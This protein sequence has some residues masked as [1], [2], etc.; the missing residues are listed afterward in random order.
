MNLKIALNDFKNNKFVSL[1]TAIFITVGASLIS[2]VLILIVNLT[3]SIDNLMTKAKTPDFLQMHQ[4]DIDLERLESF[5]KGSD[6]VKEY[7]TLD[8]LNIDRDKIEINGISQKNSVND[9]GFSVQ[10]EK[11]DYLLDLNNELIEVNPGEIYLPIIYIKDNIAAVGDK[12]KV[13]GKEFEIKGFLRDSQMNSSMAGSKRFLIHKDDYQAIENE[14]KKEYLI[15]FILNDRDKM[16]DFEKAYHDN[17]SEKNGPAVTYGMFKMINAI[18]DGIFIAVLILASIL[19][20]AISF[21]CISFSLNAKIEDE[22]R[23][24]GVMKAIGIRDKDVKKLYLDQYLIVSLIAIIKAYVLSL[25]AQNYILKDIFLYMGIS[26]NSQMAPIVAMIGMV[27]LFLI[28]VLFIS[29]MLNRIKKVSTIQAIR[30]GGAEE[31][32]LSKKMSLEKNLFFGKDFFLGL[33]EVNAK[34]K[35]YLSIFW[36]ILLASLLLTIPQNLYS[37]LKDENFMT[38]L[39]IGKTDA[40]IDVAQVDNPEILAPK[41]L[42]KVSQ[43]PRVDKYE[44]FELKTLPIVLSDG[45]EAVLKVTLGNHETFKIDYSKGRLPKDTNE[46]TLTSLYLEDL[47]LKVGDKIKVKSSGKELEIVGEYSDISNGGKTAKANFTDESLETIIA[48]TSLTL[49]DKTQIDDFMKDYISAFPEAKVSSIQ[50]YLD[51]AFGPMIKQIG[52]SRIIALIAMS[53]VLFT[54]IVL[55]TRLLIAKDR[56]QISILKTIGSSD[57]E[58]KWQIVSRFVVVTALSLIVGTIISNTLGVEITKALMGGAGLSN[59]KFVINPWISL[60]FIPAFIALIVLA[61]SRI[62]S[63]QIS[64]IKI[65]DYIKE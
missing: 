22:Y 63:N 19:I 2:L 42:D 38:N 21:L 6:L 44:N 26:S 30:T 59:I 46:I 48:S 28:I 8:F 1:A 65:S 10:S 49:K 13:A 50:S 12:A 17:I 47:G 9:N 36:I 15:E 58:I 43:D 3:G 51:Q 55:F 40:Y 34:K 31:K 32:T 57:K 54:I 37:T 64:E 7:Q 52:S 39:G 45:K 41:I 24:I 20:L 61:S 14:G 25:L 16:T 11:F 33:T 23:E 18:S 4:G 35:S 27:V 56:R 62:T 53:I 29:R 5:A 60:I